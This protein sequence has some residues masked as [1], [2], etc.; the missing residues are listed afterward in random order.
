MDT[1]IELETQ[2]LDNI[3]KK[4]R[5]GKTAKVEGLDWKNI[6]IQH[7]GAQWTIKGHSQPD[8]MLWDET[9]LVRLATAVLCSGNVPCTIVIR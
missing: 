6:V 2:V 3:R 1:D 7:K 5:N 4:T 9:Q 8:V